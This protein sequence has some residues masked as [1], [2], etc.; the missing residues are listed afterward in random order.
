MANQDII[1]AA[2]AAY[3]PVKG[4][5]DLS[6]YINGIGAI[7]TGLVEKRKIR[8]KMESDLDKY[9]FPS[10]SPQVQAVA[11]ELK[12]R[13]LDPKQNFS[14]ED[15]IKAL[16]TLKY[17]VN[18][19]LPKVNAKFTEITEKGLGGSVSP[20]AEGYVNGIAT[21]ELNQTVKMGGNSI[22]ALYAID[23]ESLSLNIM[24]MD[25][26]MTT[27]GLLYANLSN[28]PTLETASAVTTKMIGYIDDKYSTGKTSNW[29]ETS[30]GLTNYFNNTIVPNQTVF[31]AFLSDNM[32]GFSITDKNN[33]TKQI[34][35]YDHYM[36]TSMDDNQ[37]A[38]VDAGFNEIG[39][40]EVV[41]RAKQIFMNELMKGDKNLKE[42]FNGYLNK[43]KE[44]KRPEPP[45][46]VKRTYYGEV[47][48][49]EEGFFRNKMLGFSKF[50][51][52]DYTE[53]E[54]S[55]LRV[56]TKISDLAVYVDDNIFDEGEL[57]NHNKYRASGIDVELAAEEID[58]VNYL[59]FRKKTYG[60]EDAEKRTSNSWDPTKQKENNFRMVKEALNDAFMLA[61]GGPTTQGRVYTDLGI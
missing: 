55:Q 50:E 14:V 54:L 21:G 23:P 17:Q 33:N 4:Q 39:D 26:K 43:I 7:A 28:L 27:P 29:K 5:Y 45:V 20:F 22:S 59:Y 16:E 1:K 44:A 60:S 30:D 11:E 18:T 6:G 8:K 19:V 32:D 3:A 10:A 56:A 34:S 48:D 24:G 35:F 37:Q 47:D 13:V 51:I 25:G 57:S 40:P 9:Y 53:S 61:K 12:T 41:K 36:K 58:G 46:G 2:G 42:D 38:I 15:G 31:H 49:G 52:T